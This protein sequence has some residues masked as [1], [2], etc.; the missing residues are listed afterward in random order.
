MA[1]V[2]RN[3]PKRA[4][5]S[6]STYTVMD[7]ERDF[8]S[9]AV[10]MDYLWRRNFSRDGQHA[11][12]PK[13][14]RERKFHRV[15]S[16]PSYSCDTCGHHLHPTAGTI[17]HKSP[18]SLA[19]W[20]KA[21]FFMSQTRCGVSAKHLERELGVTYKTAWRMFHLIRNELMAPDDDETLIGSVE[22]DEMYVGGK[23]RVGQV[24]NKAE[25]RM[26]AEQ[27]AKVFGMA[28][29]GGK[30]VARVV[31]DTKAAT[32]MPQVATRV[33]SE[34]TIYTD[35]APVYHAVDRAG[36]QH[37]RIHHAAKVYVDGDIHTQTIDGFW[38][39]VKNGI[40][41]SHHAVSAKYLQGY[42]NEYAWRY[43]HRHD[44]KPMFLTLL[45]RV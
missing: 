28:E 35:E 4:A 9:D 30:V 33:L 19:L 10:C 8:P 22:M 23:P 34:A 18:T 38:S 42:L 37:R 17:F 44:R 40:R 11:A 15:A 29:R 12:C 32:L 25:G 31:P 39:L 13:C 16:R 36:Y 43:N 26:W 20:F 24:R 2:D 41:G 14:E 3:N 6:E 7:F 21:I 5:S 1:A 27:K 45:A